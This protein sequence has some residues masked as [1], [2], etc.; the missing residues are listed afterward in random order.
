MDEHRAHTTQSPN[1]IRAREK[2]AIVKS[3]HSK[4]LTEKTVTKLKEMIWDPKRKK[5]FKEIAKKFGVSEMQIYRIKSGEFWYHVKVDN[6]PIHAKYKKNL[7]NIA[8]LEKKSKKAKP[9]TKIE[10]TKKKGKSKKRKDK[11]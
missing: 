9:S 6:E 8:Y 2:R 1:S 5:S 7:N 11:K 3:A 10:G 4:L